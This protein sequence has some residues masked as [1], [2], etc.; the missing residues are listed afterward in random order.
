MAKK[1]K[2]TT[3]YR[4]GNFAELLGKRWTCLRDNQ[5]SPPGQ[6]HE[7][8]TVDTPFVFS[9]DRRP[10]YVSVFAS[11]LEPTVFGTG[12]SINQNIWRRTPLT[13]ASDAAFNDREQNGR[14]RFIETRGNIQALDVGFRR[15]SF[16][17]IAGLT[18][19]AQS[20]GE[21]ATDKATLFPSNPYS[22]LL[23]DAAPDYGTLNN[24]DINGTSLSDFGSPSTNSPLWIPSPYT[25]SGEPNDPNG[26]GDSVKAW[27]FAIDYFKDEASSR[28]LDPNNDITLM[29]YTGWRPHY[30]TDARNSY[31]RV[32]LI[33]DRDSPRSPA[34][35]FWD[36]G[37]W[38]E[39]IEGLQSLGFNGIG[40]DTGSNVWENG[41]GNTS[42]IDRV[43]SYGLSPMYEAVPLTDNGKV[44]AEKKFLPHGVAESEIGTLFGKPDERYNVASYWGLYPQFFDSLSAKAIFSS[45]Q[46]GGRSIDNLAFNPATTEVHVVFDYQQL[47]NT[48]FGFGL[49]DFFIQEAMVIAYRNGF[50]VSLAGVVGDSAEANAM[51]Q[52]VIDLN[53]GVAI[54]NGE[55]VVQPEDP[56]AEK[57]A[58]TG[59][60]PDLGPITI[61]GSTNSDVWYPEDMDDTPSLRSMLNL[62]DS[63]LFGFKKDEFGG[64][65]AAAD[66][67]YQDATDEDIRTRMENYINSTDT[68]N[69][70]VLRNTYLNANTTG[71]IMFDLEN[72]RNLGGINNAGWPHPEVT[73]WFVRGF[74]RRIQ[75]FR[76]FCPN[77]KIGAWR[78]GDPD[79]VYV[80][81]DFFDEKLAKFVDASNVEYNGQK[82]VDALDFYHSGLFHYR[83][84]GTNSYDRISAGGRVDQ[85]ALF[86]QTMEQEH[87]Q[88]GVKP[89]IPMYQNDYQGNHESLPGG[90][91]NDR[92]ALEIR[93][94][95][96]RGLANNH[97]MWYPTWVEMDNSVVRDT[98]QIAEFIEEYGGV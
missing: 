56:T 86:M 8:W 75:I 50:I 1:W 21:A 90:S 44:G 88:A 13:G 97:I 4:K 46:W 55:Q 84:P 5:A 83:G 96:Q 93:L 52:F 45:G 78:F 53:N 54:F 17:Q 95:A 77:A 82:F 65:Q 68:N 31:D 67:A 24:G 48:T 64:D 18:N 33:L 60:G 63:T 74:I 23:I 94:L 15:F 79:G 43:N 51:R 11:N 98:Q 10:M 27:K 70:G 41:G 37:W 76:E 6:Q 36:E 2:N 42:I 80:R 59:E 3:I 35:S 72:P 16:N 7:H 89:F 49:S 40:F 34:V 14:K 12:P 39:E 30:A 20:A 19:F 81:D 22:G 92:N 62:I 61:G 57:Y 26:V 85:I 29:C 87:G 32:S 47:K 71:H 66:Q 25:P 58:E 91:C 69:N 28:G 38:D 9:P 73:D